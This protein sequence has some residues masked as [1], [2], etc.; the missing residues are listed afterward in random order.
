MANRGETKRPEKR[1]LHRKKEK[2]YL[3]GIQRMKTRE[4]RIVITSFSVALKLSATASAVAVA[5]VT[6][7]SHLN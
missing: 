7:I 3:Q 5:A 2:A 1:R 6:H 4:K